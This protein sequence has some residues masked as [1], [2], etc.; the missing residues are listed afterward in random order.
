M[1]L[2]S[3]VSH[4]KLTPYATYVESEETIDQCPWCESDRIAK[5]PRRKGGASLFHCKRCGFI[6]DVDD[7]AHMRWMLGQRA[8]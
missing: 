5:S 6:T 1:S 3:L 7:L 4:V 8:S 2:P